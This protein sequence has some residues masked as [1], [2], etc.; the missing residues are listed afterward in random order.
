MA[1]SFVKALIAPEYTHHPAACLCDAPPVRRGLA[2]IVRAM[3]GYAG[4]LRQA[5][6]NDGYALHLAGGVRIL[7]HCAFSRHFPRFPQ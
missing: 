5:A 7:P 3:A 2:A 4:L 1:K 6:V